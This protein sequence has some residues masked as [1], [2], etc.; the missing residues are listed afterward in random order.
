MTRHETL[1]RAHAT[2]RKYHRIYKP[3]TDP[4]YVFLMPLGLN[5]YL[6]L[7]DTVSV[8]VIE[9]GKIRIGTSLIQREMTENPG[10]KNNR[11]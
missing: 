2:I 1:Y 6:V 11:E 7:T 10:E 4:C 9:N 5:L 8:S 3:K